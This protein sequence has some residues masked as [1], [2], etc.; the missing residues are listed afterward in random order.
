MKKLYLFTA[1]LTLIS[2]LASCTIQQ[3][4]V[5]NYYPQTIQRHMVSVNH[6]NELAL[7]VAEKINAGLHAVPLLNS[8]KHNLISP[9]LTTTNTSSP[10]ALYINPTKGG[11]ESSFRRTFFSALRSHLVQRDI[12]V[13]TEPDVVSANCA[14]VN[15]CRPMILDYDV[16][17]VQHEDW[18]SAT[19][20][21]SEIA[22]S[23]SITDGSLLVFSDISVF[24]IN[25][26]ESE[27]YEKQARTF[28][29]VDK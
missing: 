28:K 13:T 8:I 24:Y 26:G 2:S 25:P 17:V 20:P 21:P 10:I 5:E 14:P 18:P 23:T 6:W 9:L 3:V 1:G 22:V 4:P 19:E 16:Q 29:V 7:R 27:L 11:H 12:F 15:T